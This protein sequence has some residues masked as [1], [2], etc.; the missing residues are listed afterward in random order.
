MSHRAAQNE[1]PLDPNVLRLNF[2]NHFTP[3]GKSS[4]ILTKSSQANFSAVILGQPIM[5]SLEFAEIL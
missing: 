2:E 1:R 4:L 3:E 5:K